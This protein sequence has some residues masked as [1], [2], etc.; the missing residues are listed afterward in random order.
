M[1]PEGSSP[2]VPRA[3]FLSMYVLMKPERQVI[4]PNA[5]H[6]RW[7]YRHRMTGIEIL[8]HTRETG[9][10]QESLVHHSFEIQQETCQIFLIM[11]PVLGLGP[12]SRLLVLFSESDFLSHETYTCLQLS[13][14]IGLLH[15][16]TILGF[17]HPLFMWSR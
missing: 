11:F 6:T 13:A 3:Q 5:P 7:W 10:S 9:E 8:A 16:I 14:F 1:V 4:C 15:A 2:S 12:P 17:Q